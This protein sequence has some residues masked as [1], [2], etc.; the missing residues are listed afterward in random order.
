MHRPTS[1]LR[2]FLLFIACI[3]P[4]PAAGQSTA[5]TMFRA[6]KIYTLEADSVYA[7]RPAVAVKD[8]RI[9]AVGDSAAVAARLAQLGL[10]NY[11]V[12][13]RFAANVIV[14]GLV[15]A[16]THFQLYGTFAATPYVGYYDRPTPE[17]PLQPGV[18]TL[19]GVI[20][21]LRAELE[22]KPRVPVF[23]YGTDPIYWNG[24]RLTARELNLASRTVPIMVQM[25]SGH[26]VVCND[27][28]LKLVE[29]E[30][31][32][33]WQRLVAS[34]AVVQ[35]GG[36][37]T[38]ELDEVAAVELA[39]KAFLKARPGFTL[40]EL[41]AMERAAEMMRR[42]GITT[43]T[44]LLF[45]EGGRE[46]ER[47]G[48]T[49]YGD[50]ARAATF[51]RVY[52]AYSAAA[53]L[54][55]YGDSAA[56]HL[57]AQAAR[58]TGKIRMGPV[59]IVMDGSV[60]G[61]TAVL[62]SG[63]V[64]PPAPG[65]NPIWNVPADSLFALAQPF[66]NAGIR[67]AVHV[68]GDSA[69]QVLIR[70]VAR[71]QAAHAWADHRTTFEHNPAARPDQYAAIAEL[72]ATVNLFAGHIWY[73]GPEHERYTLGPARAADIAAADWA[74]ARSIPFSLHSDAPVTPAGPL[75]SMWNAVN[76]VMPTTPD[77]VLGPQ[78]RITVAQALRAMTMGSAYLLG[79]ETEIG[80]IKAGKYADFTVLGQDPFAVAPL[81]L[82]AVPVV[83]TV[84]GGNAWQPSTP[85]A[86]F[87]PSAS[88]AAAAQH[89]H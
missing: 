87:C 2:A 71:L 83:G 10:R 42:A 4:L 25:A 69:T 60:Q 17:G 62:S 32:A 59:K 77:S 13:R 27:T 44:D 46:L 85:T 78:H 20:E 36:R 81:R 38:G 43:A 33:Q 54:Q 79:A 55:N 29:K 26:I 51:P 23:A 37:P 70:T 31:P 22:K 9:V 75:F 68:N 24:T 61:Y 52:L 88:S 16:H 89:R 53:L 6:S 18:K 11:T 73:Y 72:G 49:M 5:A 40:Y 84:T 1:V 74:L 67:L 14:P 3:I 39:F 66:W 21:V 7:G 64:N 12:D 41:G 28:M 82:C 56:A 34:G 45:A 19:E 65:A 86:T 35:T 63:Y 47:L 50:A 8:G 30:D 57:R 58:D 15:E 76:R 80:S 48:R